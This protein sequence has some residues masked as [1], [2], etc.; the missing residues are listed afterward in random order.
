MPHPPP[1]P[2]P[3]SPPSSSP[4]PTDTVSRDLFLGG[5]LTLTQPRSG[6]RAG[7]DPV[8][9]AASV[10]ARAGQSVLDLGCGAG[11][12][13]LCLGARVAGLTL[14]GLELQP[15]YAALARRNASDN[16][17]PFEVVEGDITAIPATLK[18]R[19]F[20][21]V[22]INPPYYDRTRGSAA[23]DPAR[24]TALG[25]GAVT[26]AQWIEAAA[27]R[28]APKGYLSVIQRAERLP[29]LVSAASA[30]LGSLQLLP[31]WPRPGRDSQ[32]VILRARKS[33][34]AEFR[35]HSGILMHDAPTHESDQESYS[36]TIRAVLRDGAPLP[37][38]A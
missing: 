1:S 31:L 10:P 9:L 18:S 5:K 26:L 21:H 17:I 11:A 20:D 34:R 33:G 13:A 14:T 35:L 38:P 16:A 30:N 24:E 28:L 32:L 4:P 22:I 37:F 7:V 27:K 12:A 25:G 3:P 8:L 36:P 23:P 19:Q 6:Y 29:D 2:P 15:Q